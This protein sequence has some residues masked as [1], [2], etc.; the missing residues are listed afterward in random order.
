MWLVYARGPKPDIPWWP[1]RRLLSAIDALGWP[2]LW[3]ELLTHAPAPL[4]L[5]RPVV[6]AA[7]LLCGISRMHRA[8]CLNHRYRFTT[9]WV[10]R[11]AVGLLVI[12]LA[13]K[14]AMPA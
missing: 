12:G 8:V 1:G 14:V 13:L 11:I 3:L 6:T 5:M 7:V 10:G 2:L 4:G 9:W